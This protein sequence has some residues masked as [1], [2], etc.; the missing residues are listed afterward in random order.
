M[1]E[2]LTLPRDEA[3]GPVGSWFGLSAFFLRLLGALAVL[4]AVLA[5]ISWLA[6]VAALRVLIILLAGSA[7]VAGG[8]W[9]FVVGWGWRLGRMDVRRLRQPL[10]LLMIAWLL[11]AGTALVSPHST[12]DAPQGRGSQPVGKVFDHGP[13][14]YLSDLPKFDER[15][16]PWPI[17]KNGLIGDGG[18]TII[19]GSTSSP[20]GIG[21]HPPDSADAALKFR[22]YGEA[23]R[24]KS[25]AALDDTAVNPG[26]AAVFEV[27]SDGKPLWKSDEL[28]RPGQTQEC[29]VSVDGVDVLELR[30][31]AT[32]RSQNLHA[33]WVEPRLFQDAET[34][35]KA[36]PVALFQSGP[37]EF[38]SDLPEFGVEI[39][40]VPFAKNGDIGGGNGAIRVNGQV[41]PHGLFMHPPTTGYACAKYHL[42]KQAA[43][44]KA[45]TAI[46]DNHPPG[47]I[48]GS[49]HFEVRGD[50][51]LL[52]KSN[53]INQAKETQS[54]QVNVTGVDVLELRVVDKDI[55]NTGV[56][57]VWV[58]PRVLQTADAPDE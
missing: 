51:N 13:F 35:D 20:K 23:A 58:E 37:R 53:T 25:K 17:A 10:V 1:P 48:I 30:V 26:S 28:K 5:L 34:P 2:A 29:D 14:K 40:P 45:M 56:W 38:L 4:W 50:G 54:C 3:M 33:V 15:P 42:G 36:P 21:M 11:C 9:Y 39:G 43:V 52:W 55:V 12:A 49:C 44:F 22:L 47:V 41:S 31:R 19:L 16:G 32:G 46:N 7:L 8:A 57:A 27:L 24:F 6:P 18:R